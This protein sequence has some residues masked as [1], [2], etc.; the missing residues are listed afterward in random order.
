MSIYVIGLKYT[1]RRKD[2]QLFHNFFI[3]DETFSGHSCKVVRSAFWTDKPTK[4]KEYLN[5]KHA[6]EAM[7]QA[8]KDFEDHL[9]YLKEYDMPKRIT[10]DDLR[11]YEVRVE[12]IK[13]GA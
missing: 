6:Q 9:K 7:E 11:I 2:R 12:T 13:V 8:R 10:V 4:A 3:K 5:I 1:H